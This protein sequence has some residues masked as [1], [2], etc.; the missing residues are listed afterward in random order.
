MRKISG[1][2]ILRVAGIFLVGC[3]LADDLEDEGEIL[4]PDPTLFVPH[5]HHRLSPQLAPRR[6]RIFA[7]FVGLK[8]G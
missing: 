3:D 8:T 1:F 7:M 6:N 4:V 5:V 2:D